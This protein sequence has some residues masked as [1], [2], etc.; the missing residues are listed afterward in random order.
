[1]KLVDQAMYLLPDGTTV[2][3]IHKAGADADSR[4][5]LHHPDTG[6]LLYTVSEDGQLTGYEIIEQPPEEPRYESFPTDLSIGDL[7]RV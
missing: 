1:M 7:V 4:W 2:R 3:A 6:A 5:E